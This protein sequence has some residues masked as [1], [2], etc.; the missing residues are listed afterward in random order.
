[1]SARTFRLVDPLRL[2]VDCGQGL[3]E[4]IQDLAA[5]ATPSLPSDRLEKWAQGLV[6]T[7]A[8]VD[9]N[10]GLAVRLRPNYMKEE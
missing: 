10:G 9:E 8:E 3:Q 4:A 7:Y 2:V 6:V 5:S 1:M